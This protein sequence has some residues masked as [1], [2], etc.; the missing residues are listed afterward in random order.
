M[1]MYRYGYYSDGDTLFSK[2]VVKGEGMWYHIRKADHENYF[3]FRT[4]ACVRSRLHAQWI[5]FRLKRKY[6]NKYIEVK[7]DPEHADRNYKQY[8]CP[9]CGNL[10][11]YNELSRTWDWAGP[12]C[13]K[14]GCTGMTMF[15]EVMKYKP[16]RNNRGHIIS[17]LKKI[18]G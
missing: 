2:L 8:E 10:M 4:E 5:K 17:L 14:C 1:D 15:A 3:V 9:E 7:A 11:S 18:L 6:P 13:N 12:H 16:I